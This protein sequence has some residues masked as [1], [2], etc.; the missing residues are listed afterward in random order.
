MRLASDNV[1]VTDQSEIVVAGQG[2]SAN[3]FTSSDQLGRLNEYKGYKIASHFACSGPSA[4][5]LHG[6]AHAG[7][8]S[9]D[10]GGPVFVMDHGE[11]EMFGIISNTSYDFGFACANDIRFAKDWINA[12]ASE[13]ASD[14]RMK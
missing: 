3:S 7:A 9:G 8:M 10:S 13:M 4:V 14:F 5:E 1:N 6:P 12:S 2:L 11:L